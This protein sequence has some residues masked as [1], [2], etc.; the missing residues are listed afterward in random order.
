M[1]ALGWSRYDVERHAR[2]SPS[3]IPVTDCVAPADVF[4]D[5]NRVVEQNGWHHLIDHTKPLC[6]PSEQAYSLSPVPDAV[7]E[8]SKSH[9]RRPSE[10]E[11]K[12]LASSFADRHANR[13]TK[14]AAR[15]PAPYAIASIK[16]AKPES[17]RSTS[18]STTASSNSTASSISVATYDSSNSYTMEIAFAG[19]SFSPDFGVDFKA[20]PTP[21]AFT[22]GK[23]RSTPRS[24]F[25]FPTISYLVSTMDTPL[26]PN[27]YEFPALVNCCPKNHAWKALRPR[28]PVAFLEHF[29]ES[30]QRIYGTPEPAAPAAHSL[31]G[32]SLCP[33]VDPKTGLRCPY[34][35]TKN[36]RK[37]GKVAAPCK[38]WAGLRHY[39]VTHALTEV[40]DQLLGRMDLFKGG[41]VTDAESFKTWGSGVFVC[42]VCYALH[43]REDSLDRHLRDV[44]V[45]HLSSE[46]HSFSPAAQGIQVTSVEEHEYD[47]GQTYYE[48]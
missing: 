34:I 12:E 18:S 17:S 5:F 29:L 46:Q 26:I 38:N 47:Y 21:S 39:V 9:A 8:V 27:L 24:Q 35:H 42:H 16:H 40:K 32:S 20:A 13:A 33:Y 22:G 10:K 25:E 45:L 41:V 37:N 3:P 30:V 19:A 2:R 4:L 11:N 7:D 48:A 23:V 31:K 15:A 6:P 28:L 1:H 43:T 14:R 36:T 44:H